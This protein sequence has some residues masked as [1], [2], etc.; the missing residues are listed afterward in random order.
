LGVVALFGQALGGLNR[1]LRLLR[2]LV[3]VHTA[4]SSQ[5]I[6]FPGCGEL[7][8]TASEGAARRYMR[9]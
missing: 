7:M 4:I 5:L 6:A 3:H 8:F 2:E 9:R 1:L